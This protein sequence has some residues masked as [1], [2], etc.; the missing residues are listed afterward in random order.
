[1]SVPRGLS[2]PTVTMQS[3][4]F[5]ISP[6][7]LNRSRCNEEEVAAR[8]VVVSMAL[9][10]FLR[11]ALQQVEEDRACSESPSSRWLRER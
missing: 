9:A 7:A 11:I 3:R 10:M 5:P 6:M 1:M 2:P 8:P 4:T